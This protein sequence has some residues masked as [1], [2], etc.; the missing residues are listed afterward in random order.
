[1]DFN[2]L[3]EKIDALPSLPQAYHKCCYLLEQESTDSNSLA[4]I[5]SSDLAMTVMVLRVVNSA[6]YNL[7]RKIERIDHA[8]SIIGHQKFKELILTTVIV[9]AMSKLS[10]SNINIEAFW[11]HSVF[12][13]LIA[14]RLALY[15]YL[16]NADRLHTAG[17]VHD[18]GQ[19][20]YF[21]ML[22]TKALK[23]CELVSKFEIEPLVAEQKVLGF[24]HHDIGAALCKT[25]KLPNW[26]IDVVSYYNEP[27]SSTEF[28]QECRVVSLAN[29]IA[30]QY[31]PDITSLS[32]NN[33][34]KVN[35][36]SEVFETKLPL[37]LEDIEMAKEEAL[38]QL[39]DILMAL[40]P[41]LKCAK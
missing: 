3:I 11:R 36:N 16:P 9:D 19:L 17:L 28:V 13:G 20:I 35:F 34:G 23:V 26:L 38:E 21:T 41:K 31:F 37:S 12:T 5:V 18:V 1:M 29:K 24:N 2:L 4:T 32:P 25:W 15:S 40:I 22:S 30:N 8:I 6:L 14:K 27:E 10:N 7:P 39:E 33:M